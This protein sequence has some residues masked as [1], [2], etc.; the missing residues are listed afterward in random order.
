M[1]SKN[2][3]SPEAHYDSDDRLANGLGVFSLGLGLAEIAAP[4]QLA[5]FIGVSDDTKTRNI[6]RAYGAREIGTGLGILSERQPASW[7]WGRVGG[8]VLDIATLGV[9][10]TRPDADK[11][12][13]GR[14]I[15]M[16]VGVT[17]LDVICAQRLS[18]K[19]DSDYLDNNDEG[20][21]VIRT[22]TI[23][24]SPEEVYQFWRKFENLPRFMRHLEKVEVDDTDKFTRW[25]AKA[26]IG[27]ITWEA[28]TITDIPG[29]LIAWQ[30]LPGS[31]V[32]NSGTV[33]FER[34]PGDRGTVVTV[35]LRYSPP[36]GTVG[37]VVAKMMGEEPGM[38]IAHDLRNF[39]QIME[40][41]EVVESDASIHSGMHPAQP[42]K[43]APAREVGVQL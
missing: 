16:V 25:T 43:K 24:K 33:R 11:A 37:T 23:N 38:Q 40:I 32:D 26:P 29:K 14:A 39:K 22:I 13:I 30:S 9:A 7:M 15:A 27:T 2:W 1:E 8:D 20:T 12:K 41:G 17:A 34:A 19:E 3:D 21:A 6:L 4:G 36:G 5:N 42:P 18:A 31:T 28:Q 10:M 35:D